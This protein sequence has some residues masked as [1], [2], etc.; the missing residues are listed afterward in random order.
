MNVSHISKKEIPK[1]EDVKG[2]DVREGVFN[3]IQ[4]SFPEFSKD[5]YIS[6]TE[7]NQYRRSI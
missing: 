6:L 7:L 5:S 1:G 4:S 3:L 2:Q